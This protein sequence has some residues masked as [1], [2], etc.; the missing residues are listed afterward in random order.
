MKALRPTECR[1]QTTEGE[2]LA[3]I[4][5]LL[6]VSRKNSHKLR[7]LCCLTVVGLAALLH[8][9]ASNGGECLSSDREV[10]GMAASS[11]DGKQVLPTRSFVCEV[12]EETD[13]RIEFYRLNDVIVGDL[14]EGRESSVAKQVLGQFSIHNNAVYDEVKTLFDRF[15]V[16]ETSSLGWSARID[17]GEWQ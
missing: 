8:A 12:D 13:V 7:T 17:S 15:G 14:L 16:H 3:P 6:T 2:V 4:G 11:G 9:P 10:K 1:K 5:P